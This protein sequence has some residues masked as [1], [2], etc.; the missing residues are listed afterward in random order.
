MRIRKDNARILTVGCSSTNV[1]IESAGS[2]LETE[3]GHV[4]NGSRRAS[5]GELAAKAATLPVP[6]NVPLKDPKDFTVIG[7]PVKRLDTLDKITGRASFGI[8][9]EAPGMLVALRE[10]HSAGHGDALRRAAHSLKS[11]ALTFGA[12]ALAAQARAIELDGL[13]NDDARAS[14]AIAV[15]TDTYRQAAAALRELSDA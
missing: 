4:E 1:L 2:D 3:A 12:A 14:A 9:A 5:Y 8:D 10:A 6:E 15:L 13:G 11:N 7:K